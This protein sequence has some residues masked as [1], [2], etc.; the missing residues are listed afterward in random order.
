MKFTIYVRTNKVGSTVEHIVDLDD[1][2]VGE[3]S[4]DELED[5]LFEEIMQNGLVEWWFDQEEE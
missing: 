5:V 4:A 3:M 2:D 1:E